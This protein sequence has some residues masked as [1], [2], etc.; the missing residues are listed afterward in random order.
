MNEQPKS[1]IERHWRPV[2]MLA[3]SAVVVYVTMGPGR[4][5]PEVKG[6]VYFLRG[7]GELLG[8]A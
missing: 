1:W 7:L 6:L 3:L 5:T 4:D 8:G 2:A